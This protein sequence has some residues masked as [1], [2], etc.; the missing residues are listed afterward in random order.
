VG[1]I[2][3]RYQSP[4]TQPAGI[5]AQIARALEG[6]S[7]KSESDA[8]YNWWSR[9]P[10]ITPWQKHYASTKLMDRLNEEVSEKTDVSFYLRQGKRGPV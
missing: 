2:T 7:R 1:L 5:G 3:S 6:E 4:E 9:C 10:A 8:I